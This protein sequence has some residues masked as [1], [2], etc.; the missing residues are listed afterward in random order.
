MIHKLLKKQ[1]VGE[2]LLITWHCWARLFGEVPPES[3]D[4]GFERVSNA[5]CY[6]HTPG[7]LSLASQLQPL[8]LEYLSPFLE[9]FND[10]AWSSLG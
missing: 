2:K 4:R 9:V 5:W 3:T 6:Q 1:G 10:R 7:G 8:L